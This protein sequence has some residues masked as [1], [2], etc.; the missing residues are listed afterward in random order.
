MRPNLFLRMTNVT[1]LQCFFRV[2]GPKLETHLKKIAQCCALVGQNL[3]A[4]DH[5]YSLFLQSFMIVKMITMCE[6]LNA[7]SEHVVS[8]NAFS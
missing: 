6:A 8:L 5:K 3:S 4:R 2:S 7:V 1:Q